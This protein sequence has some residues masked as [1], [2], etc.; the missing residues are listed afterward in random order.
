MSDVLDQVR[1][2]NPVRQPCGLAPEVQQRIVAAT[3]SSDRDAMPARMRLVRVFAGKTRLRVFLVGAAAVCAAGGTALAIGLSG[4]Q[5]APPSGSLSSP[6]WAALAAAKGYAVNVTPDPRAG[7]VGWCV[8]TFVY[9]QA[10]GAGGNYGC[11]YAPV[12]GEPIVINAP[13]G[14]ASR[15][16]DV[17]TSWVDDVFVTTAQV[18]A[19]RVSPRL[20]IRTL[21]DRQLPDQYRIAIYVQ[22]TVGHKPPGLPQ[23]QPGA[24]ALNSK[25]EVMAQIASPNEQ[26]HDASIFWP[27]G[28][29][30]AAPAAA[31]EIYTGSLHGAFGGVVKHIRPISNL[32]DRAFLS[33]AETNLTDPQDRGAAAAILLDAQHP[34][35]SAPAPLPDAK[36]VPG[37]QGTF[38]EPAIK[39]PSTVRASPFPFNTPALA[40][41]GRR[42]GNAWL[43]V[44]S[45]GTIQQRLA[46][47]DQLSTCIHLNGPA[48]AAP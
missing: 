27:A 40:I 47:L 28:H 12:L 36:P 7:Q 37:H 39:P 9:Q 24:V 31:C 8:A 13:G 3:V 14:G 10:G 6:S 25:G 46:V 48:C 20:T 22:Q 30:R 42:I 1:A 21:R 32:A 26:P 19:V 17:R 29:V 23:L 4:Q 11:G 38:N 41:T 5:S 43:I 18:A 15:I 16:G 33:C 45:A 34:D 35:R 2:A 44:Q